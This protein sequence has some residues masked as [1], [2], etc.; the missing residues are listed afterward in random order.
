V[1]VFLGQLLQQRGGLRLQ[2]RNIF[3]SAVRLINARTGSLLRSNDELYWALH[4]TLNLI[5]WF[6]GPVRLRL[7]QMGALEQ[8]AEMTKHVL[9]EAPFSPGK[10]LGIFLAQSA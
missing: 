7:R 2:A 3:R 5:N 1:C 6:L 10:L 4:T 8:W 9:D